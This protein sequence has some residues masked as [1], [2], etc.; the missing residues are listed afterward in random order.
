MLE[1]RASAPAA[2]AQGPAPQKKRERGALEA[3]AA[4]EQRHLRDALQLAQQRQRHEA[5]AEDL[6]PD[7]ALSPPLAT[8]VCVYPIV[9]CYLA[10]CNISREQ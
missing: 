6:I 3:S 7:T 4:A 9:K 1:S 10:S 5:E 2:M 8:T